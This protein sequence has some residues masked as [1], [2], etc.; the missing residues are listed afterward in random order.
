[1]LHPPR[2]PHG[3][4]WFLQSGRTQPHTCQGSGRTEAPLRAG[5]FLLTPGSCANFTLLF[6][7]IKKNTL[8]YFFPLP[9][10][11]QGSQQRLSSVAVGGGWPCSGPGG[12][13]SSMSIPPRR[14][15]SFFPQ[16]FCAGGCIWLVGQAGSGAAHPCD[17]PSAVLLTHPF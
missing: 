15:S 5:V 4:S 7:N 14:P 17:L 8:V 10:A 2:K 3:G 6:F 12:F 13:Y 16:Q 11:Q 1:M 9:S